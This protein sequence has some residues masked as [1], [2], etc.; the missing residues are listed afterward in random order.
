ML[1]RDYCGVIG[2][3]TL[4]GTGEV[5]KKSSEK[6]NEIMVAGPGFEPVWAKYY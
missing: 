4:E 3:S 2:L 6:P 5:F 1:Q